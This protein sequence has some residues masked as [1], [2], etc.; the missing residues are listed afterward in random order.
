MH[1]PALVFCTLPPVGEQRAKGEM[2]NRGTV[3]LVPALP[4]WLPS[5]YSGPHLLAGSPLQHSGDL[6]LSLSIQARLRG[7]S[8]CGD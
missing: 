7:T 3:A 1:P 2:V 5:V 8:F 4:D 6:Y